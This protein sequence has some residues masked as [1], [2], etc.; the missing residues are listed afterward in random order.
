MDRGV[1]QA[2]VPGSQRVRQDLMTK[3]THITYRLDKQQG[4]TV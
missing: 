4:T 2:T 1:W 3:H